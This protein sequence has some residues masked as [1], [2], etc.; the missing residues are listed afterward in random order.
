MNFLYIWSGFLLGLF[1]PGSVPRC[2]GVQAV[3]F[4][5]R[6]YWPKGTLL[7]FFRWRL[8]EEEAV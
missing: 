6:Q 3:Q 5:L 7:G 2:T 8:K 4:E 1:W